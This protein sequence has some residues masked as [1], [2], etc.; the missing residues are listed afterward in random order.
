MPKENPKSMENKSPPMNFEI[1]SKASSEAEQIRHEDYVD[2]A[3]KIKV[4]E[5]DD[6]VYLM[7]ESVVSK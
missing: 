3:G 7:T 6:Y 5:Q 2:I 1:I 4:D